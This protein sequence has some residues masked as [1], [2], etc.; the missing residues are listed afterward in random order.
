MKKKEKRQFKRVESRYILNCRKIEENTCGVDAI[1]KD[2]SAA[3][4]LF[5][6]PSA[7][8]PGDILHIE[9]TLPGWELF[10]GGKA[11]EDEGLPEDVHS[12]LATVVR[13]L[14]HSDGFYEVAV[15]FNELDDTDKRLLA[16]YFSDRYAKF[17]EL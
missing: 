4:I 9:M 5:E 7:Y 16:D 14:K 2:I 12:V 13:A 3:G 15:C 11:A 17:D 10:R 8:E 1:T 6:A